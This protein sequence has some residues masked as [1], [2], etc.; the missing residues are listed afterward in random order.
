MNSE[1]FTALDL[2]E[3]ERGIPKEYML[4]R[5]EAALVSAYKRENAGNTNVRVSIDPDNK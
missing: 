1:F 3:K 2:L 4:E 5:V